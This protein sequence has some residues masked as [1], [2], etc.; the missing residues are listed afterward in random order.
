MSDVQTLDGEWLTYPAAAIRLGKSEPAVRM[1]A[2]RDKWAPRK[3]GRLTEVCV[4]S[5]ELE[6][7]KRQAEQA[8]T[9]VATAVNNPASTAI[10]LQQD[11]TLAGLLVRLSDQAGQL[12][13]RDQR[14]GVLQEQLRTVRRD[15]RRAEAMRDGLNVAL[16]KLAGMWGEGETDA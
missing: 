11:Q 4:P 10:A 7:A 14:I 16:A 5:A 6:A 9:A 3:D 13:E 2:K 12:S 8:E 15:L 1:Q